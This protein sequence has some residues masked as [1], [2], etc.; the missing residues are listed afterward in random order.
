MGKG[1]RRAQIQQLLIDMEA[2]AEPEKRGH[3]FLHLWSDR[4]RQAMQ[5]DAVF[6][7]GF[8]VVAHVDKG[9]FEPVGILFQQVDGLEQKVIGI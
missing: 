1:F 2:V 4:I 9:R 5:I 3:V 7:E 8:A 6:A